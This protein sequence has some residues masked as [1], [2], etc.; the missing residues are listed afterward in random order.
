M[1]KDIKKV[2]YYDKS[3]YN[4]ENFLSEEKAKK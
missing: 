2:F 3:L 1:I 4:N